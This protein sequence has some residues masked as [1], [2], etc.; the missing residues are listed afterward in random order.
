MKLR[1]KKGD[2]VVVITGKNRGKRGKVIKILPDAGRLIV[3]G[4]NMIK[5][6]ERSRKQGQSGQIIEAAAPIDASN[7]QLVCQSCNRGVRTGS[8]IV[9]NSRQRVCR[10]CGR[11]I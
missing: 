9:N 2:S 5:R 7:V 6:H 4:V 11:A 1:I 10:K 8:N 3:E